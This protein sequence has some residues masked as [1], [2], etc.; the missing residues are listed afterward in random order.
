M[1]SL[2]FKYKTDTTFM[3]SENIKVFHPHKLLLDFTDKIKKSNLKVNL[4][5]IDKYAAFS[6]L[7]IYYT[8]EN[9]KSYLKTI[10]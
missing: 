10:N 3:N 9:I 4:K 2:Q 6:N 7:I 5:K 8:W 1:N